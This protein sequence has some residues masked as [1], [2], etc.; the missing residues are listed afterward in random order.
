MTA[1]GNRLAIELRKHRLEVEQVEL[2]RCPGHEQKNHPP[3]T[4][5][6]MRS[7]RG[8]RIA[9]GNGTGR[10]SG[11]GSPLLCPASREASAI[12]PTPTP[13][14]WKKCPARAVH[15]SCDHGVL[16][17]LIHRC[18]RPKGPTPYSFV[19]VSSRFSIT[20]ATVV[21][22]ASCFRSISSGAESSDVGGRCPV[23]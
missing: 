3:R 13:Q 11:T 5:R 17:S 14:S 7:F 8:H 15:C 22:A 18:K 20:R 2:A 16:A 19:T 4:C 23:R 12:L 1:G 10:R 9:G 21:Q 6:Q